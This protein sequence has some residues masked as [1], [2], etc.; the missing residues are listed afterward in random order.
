[1][2]D[3]MEACENLEMAVSAIKKAMT[4]YQGVKV[5]DNQDGNHGEAVDGEQGYS[6]FDNVAK[7]KMLISK[8]M[9]E[10]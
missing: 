3:M 1:M 7:K 9:Q 8:M 5:E 4:K 6:K 2:K 10:G